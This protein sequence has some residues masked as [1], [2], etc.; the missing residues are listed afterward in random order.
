MAWIA[1]DIVEVLHP[2]GIGQLVERGDAPVRVRPQ[3]VSDEI[4]PDESR[5]A[6]DDDI[7]HACGLHS[8]HERFRLR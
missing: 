1:G 4:R 8:L 3:R 6:G 5:A 2:A 7:P